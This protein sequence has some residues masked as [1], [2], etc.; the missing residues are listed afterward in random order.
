MNSISMQISDPSLST[1][2]NFLRMLRP[3][4][5]YTEIEA[6]ALDAALILHMEHDSIKF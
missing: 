6:K 2:E 5:S 3:D 1:A 4:S